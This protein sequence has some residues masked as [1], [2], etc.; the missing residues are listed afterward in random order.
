MYHPAMHQD[1][2][3]RIYVGV[4][5]LVGQGFLQQAIFEMFY[6]YVEI[7]ITLEEFSGGLTLQTYNENVHNIV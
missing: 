5:M 1:V 4:R 2:Q 7:Y 3:G 6:L